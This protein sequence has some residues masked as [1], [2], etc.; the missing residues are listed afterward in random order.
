M[1]AMASG[2]RPLLGQQRELRVDAHR[3]RER[4]A[5]AAVV[6]LHR[7]GLSVP[8]ATIAADAG[9][10]IG[11][12]YRHFPT[13]D[14]LLDELTFRS[15]HLM[16][17]RIEHARANAGSATEA[18]RLFLSAVIR[19]RHQMILPAT[20]GP[21]VASPR[22]RAV[23]SELHDS[24]EQLL[25]GGVKDG[26]ILRKVDVWDVAWLGATLAQP[27]RAGASWDATCLRLL[28]TYLAGLGVR[29]N[30]SA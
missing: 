19:D 24:I 2:S 18:L 29:Q 20:G 5:R 14:D 23:Q 27:G 25:A 16:L 11:T 26:T 1:E 6:T 9:V 8:M 7:E 28:D 13:R 21:Q 12:L 22:T 4:L 17:S 30:G 10:G 15:F 3:N